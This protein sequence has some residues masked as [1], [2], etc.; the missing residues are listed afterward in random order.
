[1][2]TP[3]FIQEKLAGPLPGKASQIKMAPDHRIAE[4]FRVRDDDFNPR[5]SAVLCLLFP[6]NGTL[7][8]IFI[9]RSEY[10][11]IHSGQISFPGGRYEESD[12]DLLVTALREVY[13]EIGIR[14]EDVE[15]LGQLTDL[16]VP[17]SNFMVRTFVA[18]L[19]QKPE[20][21]IDPREVQEII[22]VELDYLFRTDIIRRKDFV[23]HN[24]TI[25]TNAPYF[26]VDGVIIWGATAMI[27]TELADLLK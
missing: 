24:S 13:E 12:G 7:K 6:E 4:L 11:G 17:P 15:I 2:M 14:P 27:L 25:N 8:V 10:V 5:L 1:M 16:Y 9:R 21:L 23:A 19:K 20:Y 18:Y 22:E 26:D 3:E